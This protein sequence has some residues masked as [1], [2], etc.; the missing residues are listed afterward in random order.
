MGTLLEISA[1]ILEL[2]AKIAAAETPE[3]E[4]EAVLNYFVCEGGR[5]EKID[6]YAAL[7]AETEARSEVRKQE[8]ERLLARAKTDADRVSFLRA[9]LLDFFTRHD[10]TTLET[11]RFRVTRGK[12]EGRPGPG[13]VVAIP[14]VELPSEFLREIIT[15]RADKD[16]LRTALESGREIEGVSLKETGYQV[17]IS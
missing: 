4:E 6:N 11:A 2:E 16:A 14:E 7:I 5:D 15:I 12:I 8:G 13:V 10:L 17:R 1:D 9:R 3:Q